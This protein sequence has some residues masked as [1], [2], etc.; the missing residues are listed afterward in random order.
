MYYKRVAPNVAKES[1][2]L[3]HL[4]EELMASGCNNA[5]MV[6]AIKKVRVSA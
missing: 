1:L 4:V 5:P 2:F 6:L 3:L